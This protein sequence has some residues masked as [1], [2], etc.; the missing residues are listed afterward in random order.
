MPDLPELSV[1]EVRDWTVD[2]YYERGEGYF[3]ENRVHHT[4]I[5]GQRLKALC[6]GSRPNPY[7][8]EITLGND[9]IVSGSCSCPIGDGGRCKHAVALLLTWVETPNSFESIEPLPARLRAHSKE[10]LIT[11][12]QRLVQQE[13][14]LESLVELSL[15]GPEADHVESVRAYVEQAF[16]VAG[17]DPY[18][19]GY[20]GHVAEHLD[21]LLERGY[22]HITHDAWDEAIPLFATVLET[23]QDQYESVHDEDGALISVLSTCAEGLGD[24]LSAA[25]DEKLR[26]E[27]LEALL[28]LYLWDVE[29]GGY[30]AGPAAAEALRK[31][32]TDDER[33]RAADVLRDNLPPPPDDA[34]TSP[35]IYGAP[36]ASTRWNHDDWIREQL[37]DL[38]LDLERDRLDP[39]EYLA[40]CRRTGQW[41]ECTDRLLALNRMEDAAEAAAQLPDPQLKSVLD[42]FVEQGAADTARRLV[43]DR[44]DTDWPSP[45]LQQWLYEH[46]RRTDNHEQ[47]LDVARR[48]FAY[49]PSLST[50]D[51]VREE[52]E[53]LGQWD[54]IRTELLDR[55]DDHHRHDL[56]VRIYL[57]ENNPG[58]ALDLVE[59][60][61]GEDR[62]RAFG[63]SFL[64]SVADDVAEGHPNAALALYEECAQRLI[65]RR[66]RSNY[67]DA[68]DLLQRA[69]AVSKEQ[70]AT[71]DFTSF[72]D[73]LYEEELHRLPA[74]Q[75]EFEQAGLL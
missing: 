17:L 63:V 45:G 64:A 23:V 69:K 4:R 70:D 57:H 47:A 31:Q 61:A 44:L 39:D 35:S 15:G 55:L 51:Q 67:A 14:H 2:R 3:H 74:A 33:R 29:Q 56:L 53:A 25:D 26:S 66:G 30:G 52:A 24:V 38:L 46:T 16:E 9:G 73:A 58:T 11:V 18:D 32:T 13:P 43:Q 75:D 1:A 20:A 5:E 65:D 27:A 60:F 49:Q 37:G 22:E 6:D 34:S 72:L 21:P 41:A 7:R 19:Y 36:S 71:D 68:A 10:E 8:V 50:F 54:T 42:R 40:L 28:D 62:A 12:I 59:P 48:I